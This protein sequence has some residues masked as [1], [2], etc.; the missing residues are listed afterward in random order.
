MD[1]KPWHI[2]FDKADGIIE[3]YNG[4]RFLELFHLHNEIYYSINSRIYNAIFDRIN[5]LISKK[6]DDK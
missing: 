2:L 3:I 4:I 6:S 1:A 5:Y